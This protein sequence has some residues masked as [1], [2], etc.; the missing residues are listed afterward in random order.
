MAEAQA[1]A[2]IQMAQQ[3]QRRMAAQNDWARQVAQQQLG[4]DQQRMLMNQRQFDSGQAHALKLEG[5][6]Q[7]GTLGEIMARAM[8]QKELEGVRH[9]NTMERDAAGFGRQ[10]ELDQADRAF[11]E[12]QATKARL[13]ARLAEEREA[14]RESKRDRKRRVREVDDRDAKLKSQEV[15]AEIMAELRKAEAEAKRDERIAGMNVDLVGRIHR[16]GAAVEKA[17]IAAEEESRREGAKRDEDDV[18]ASLEVKDILAKNGALLRSNT[19]DDAAKARRNAF[20]RAQIDLALHGVSQEARASI[21]A[22]IAR[23]FPDLAAR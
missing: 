23:S 20:I 13:R 8:Q 16:E 2:R 9:S 5:M 11:R 17:R 1:W 7:E 6:R 18:A 19:G 3:E 15:V 12:R 10:Q 22:M 21:E 4:M 14:R